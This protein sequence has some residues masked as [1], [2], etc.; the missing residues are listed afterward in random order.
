MSTVTLLLVRTM[1]YMVYLMLLFYL[2]VALEIF[3]INSI[4]IIW[5]YNIY[6]MEYG[7]IIAWSFAG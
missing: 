5:G 6:N 7:T 4:F 3:H 1:S 2:N